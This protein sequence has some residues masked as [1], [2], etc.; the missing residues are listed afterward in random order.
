MSGKGIRPRREPIAELTRGL[1]LP[2]EPIP[3]AI[4]E[5]IA[6]ILQ[7]EWSCLV[8]EYADFMSAGDEIAVNSLLASRLNSLDDPFW[9]MMVSS[10]VR[11][12][13]VVS[14]D[15][16]H[17]EKKPD[18]SLHLTRRHPAFRLEVECKLID[19]TKR[20]SVSVYTRDGLA[21]F[22][23]GEY[24]WGTREAFMLAYVRDGSKL[25]DSLTPFLAKYKESADD[26]YGTEELPVVVGNRTNLA[27]SSHRRGFT[28]VHGLAP[29]SPGPIVIWHLWL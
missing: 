1:S 19:S 21:R 4:L 8:H 25:A 5:E 9:R 12:H 22:L 15:G 13:S 17:L 7:R 28:Y 11:D 26:P 14:F 20:K 3:P 6:T 10:V 18:L 27:W 2:L 16:S 24:A 23:R 29:S